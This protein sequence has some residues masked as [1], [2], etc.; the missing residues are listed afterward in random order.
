MDRM[1]KNARRTFADT[2][3]Q[4]AA[5]R[6]TKNSDRQPDG[7]VPLSLPPN[8]RAS[9]SLHDPLEDSIPFLLRRTARLFRIA[10]QS[11]MR[12][13]R[14][15]FSH[16]FYLRALWL[17]DGITQ[18]ELC[19]RIDAAEPAAVTALGG[20]ER[21]GYIRR[22]RDKNHGRRIHIFITPKGAALRDELLPYAFE[23]SALGVKG[24]AKQD[25]STVRNALNL[26]RKNMSAVVA[27]I[28]T[29]AD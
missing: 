23:L 19:R 11:R 12:E 27:G 13:N 6:R 10:I 4:T 1:S 22:V 16:W 17:E 5:R 9:R 15:G 26:I 3:G 29:D 28:D 2:R 24:I 14:L 18:R 21:H 20:L 25:L 8:S 7:S